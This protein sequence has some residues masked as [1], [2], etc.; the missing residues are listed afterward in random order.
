M[1]VN[2]SEESFLGCLSRREQVKRVNVMCLLTSKL[3]KVLTQL[4]WKLAS[5]L[6]CIKFSAH[7]NFLETLLEKQIKK[8]LFAY[9][10]KHV[11]AT[12]VKF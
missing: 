2:F 8:K 12:A 5:T 7:V 4:V 10:D 9:N 11:S 3:K 1:R 6:K